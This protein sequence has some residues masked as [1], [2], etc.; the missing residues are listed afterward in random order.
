MKR[1][2]LLV[3][4]L[5]FTS[6]IARPQLPEGFVQEI[7]NDNVFLPVGI[8]FP[9]SETTIVWDLFGQ[10]WAYPNGEFDWTPDI[11]IREEVARYGDLG[12]IGAAAHPDFEN[13]GYVYL[14]YCVDFHYIETFGTDQ[15]DPEF[16]SEE[17][18]LGRITRYTIDPVSLTLVEGSRKI[19]LGEEIDEG[20]PICA[21]AHGVGSLQFGE[22]GSL[23]ATSGDGNTWVGT[24]SSTGFNGEGT[25]PEFAYDDVALEKGL[26]TEAENLGAFRA[27]YLDGLNGKVLRIH[28]ETGEGLPN[29]PFYDPENP[30]AKRSKVWALGFRNPY[31]F[32]IRPGTGWGNLEDGHPGTIV[33]SDV[34]DWVWEEV[35]V[36]VDKGSNFGW[37]MFQGPMVYGY[38][39]NVS[40]TNFNAPNPLAGENCSPYMDYQDVIQ[41]ENLQHEN[42]FSNPCNPQQLIPESINTFVHQRP[43]LAFA[44]SANQNNEIVPLV[45]A[46]STFDEN[47]NANFTSIEEMDEIEGEN[48]HGISGTGGV[49]IKGENMPPEYQGK[50][51]LA[52]YSGWLKSIEFDETDQPVRIEPWSDDIGAVVNIT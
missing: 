47:G 31:R 17:I 51:L 34:G 40:T 14:F 32:T 4:F 27:Q 7:A 52:D 36:V 2:I 25:P 9:T 3:I 1:A 33:L 11:D 24:S 37:P 16:T 44:N 35:N 46:V 20:I 50:Y 18:S 45:A 10:V 42:D 29:N 22:D 38:Y 6:V 28:P 41:Q 13:N 49:F 23:I 21:P 30:D 8:L 19:I 5:V 26:I 43:V 39:N 48:F 12:L 15:Y